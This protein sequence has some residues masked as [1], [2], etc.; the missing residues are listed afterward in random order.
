MYS[1]QE[2][3]SQIDSLVSIPAVYQRICELI[4]TPGSS[5]FEIADLLTTDPALTV[6][7]LRVVNS[8]M[9]GFRGEIDNM[10]RAVQILGLQQVHDIVLGVSLQQMFGGLRPEGIDI[11]RYW[12]QSMMSGLC[13]RAIARASHHP[14]PERMF[15]VGL[16]GNIGHL[17]MY[18]TTPTLAREAERAAASGEA[19]H[20]AERR[21]IG[22]DFAEV[23]ATLMDHW[24]VPRGFAGAIGAQTLPRLGGDYAHEAAIVHLAHCIAR[25]DEQ[26]EASADIVARI[27]SALWPLIGIE[28][29]AVA[30]I[31]EDAE[32]NL[33]AHMT[34]FFPPRQR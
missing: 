16:L 14:S 6:R 11:D 23:G 33:A 3:V 25:A 21:I 29:D 18:Q 19:L 9:F 12:R 2:L 10:Q 34:L 5:M 8:A 30:Q 15:V 13:A 32:L 27:E 24:G 26:G 31:R 4:D 1:A 28:A 20:L 7:L 17:V 22:C